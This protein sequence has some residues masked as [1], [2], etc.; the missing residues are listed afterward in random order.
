MSSL[1]KSLDSV[2]VDPLFQ[3]SPKETSK[4]CEPSHVRRPSLACFSERF[5]E[6]LGS[7]CLDSQ[8]GTSNRQK[9]AEGILEY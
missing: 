6:R 3:R 7:R 1:P 5:Y 4:E 8:S 9:I 2:E